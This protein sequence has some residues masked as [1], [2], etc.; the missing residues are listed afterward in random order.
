MVSITFAAR[1]YRPMSS[2]RD[3]AAAKPPENASRSAEDLE[4]AAI[5]AQAD[6]DC[7]ANLGLRGKDANAF[8][9]RVLKDARARV[10]AATARRG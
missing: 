5:L 1:Y 6:R 8:L 10:A 4:T 3:I 7:D 9:G 2:R